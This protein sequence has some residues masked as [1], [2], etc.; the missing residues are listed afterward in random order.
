M[1]V[2]ESAQRTTPGSKIK[3]K[4]DRAPYEAWTS[5]TSCP[6]FQLEC[7]DFDLIKP[8]IEKLGPGGII[9]DD[10]AM[11][12][13]DNPD[14][15]STVESA[16]VLAIHAFNFGRRFN[17]VGP[18]AA[19]D[20]PLVFDTGASSGLSPFKCNLLSDYKSVNVDVKCVAGGGSIIGG[21]TILRRLKIRYGTKL[22]IPSHGYHFPE[23][24][25]RLESSHSLIRAMEGSG[26]AIV[27]GWN[28]E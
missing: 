27:D 11:F 14:S 20:T 13:L 19:R 21:G 7:P 24:D 26:H 25:I 15:G 9:T 22:L 28:I 12:Y 6:I 2:S 16:Q 18:R 1:G 3:L 23:A 17:K 5:G 4:E 8:I 10:L